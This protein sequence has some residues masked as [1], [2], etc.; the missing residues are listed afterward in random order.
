MK[1]VIIGAGPAGITAAYEL[2]KKHREHEVTIFECTD[3]IGG[4][5]QTVNYKGNRM[6]IGGHRFFSKSKRVTDWWYEILQPQGKPSIDDK[7]LN[8]KK[9]YESSGADPEKCDEV[10]LKRHRVSRIYYKNK[11]FDYPVTM[12]PETIKN[13]G[14]STILSA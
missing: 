9:E 14:F 4:I 11:F 1:V 13:M 8:R 2:R 6:D 10:M 5:S 12:K 7:L 3:R